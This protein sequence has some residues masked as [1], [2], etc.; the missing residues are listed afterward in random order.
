MNKKI[1]IT[2]IPENKEI[3]DFPEDTEFIL[4]EH[5]PMADDSINFINNYLGFL[6][7]KVITINERKNET[8]I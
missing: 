6:T 1:R 5:D 8:D 7:E 2:E 4:D 3:E